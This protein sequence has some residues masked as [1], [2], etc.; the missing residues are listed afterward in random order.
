MSARL[1]PQMAYHFGQMVLPLCVHTVRRQ[2]K[3]RASHHMQ[4][5]GRMGADCSLAWKHNQFPDM[6]SV[7]C[8]MHHNRTTTGENRYHQTFEGVASCISL[9]RDS[10]QRDVLCYHGPGTTTSVFG[11]DVP[12]GRGHQCPQW[13]LVGSIRKLWRFV[14]GCNIGMHAA[15][16]K[17]VSEV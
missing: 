14:L 2:S 12:C 1:L 13:R 9:V 5:V 11:T 8:D 10:Y 6:G 17:A 16:G 3:R 7:A 4:S 15:Y